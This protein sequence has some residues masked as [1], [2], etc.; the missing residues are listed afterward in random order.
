MEGLEVKIE[1]GEVCDAGSLLVSTSSSM[2]IILYESWC[3]GRPNM[4]QTTDERNGVRKT[5]NMQNIE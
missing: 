5:R 2:D 3:W 4:S 1:L